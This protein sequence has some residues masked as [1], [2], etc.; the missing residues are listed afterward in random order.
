MAGGL[1]DHERWVRQQQREEERQQRA[2]A[3]A[4][5]AAERE[6]K[7]QHTAACQAQVELLKGKLD[8]RIAELESILRHGLMRSSRLDLRSLRRVDPPPSLDLGERAY[9]VPRPDWEQFRPPAPGVLGGFFGGRNRYA[10]Q[11]ADAEATFA[12]AERDRDAAEDRRQAWVREQR[13]AHGAR[14][15]S[16]QAEVDAH[17]ADIVGWHKGCAARDRESVERYLKAISERVPLPRDLPKVA[18]IAYSPRGEQVVARVELPGTD[19]VP[20]V[21]RYSYVVSK[22]EQRETARPKA[23]VAQLYRSIVSQIALLYVRDLFDA[24]PALQTVDVNGHVH[25]TNPATGHREYPCLISVT[26]ERTV[27]DSLNLREVSPQDCLRHL[28]ALVSPHPYEVEP[29]TPIREFDLT[30]FA[31]VDGLDAVSRLDSRPD[32]I[33]MTSTEFEHFVRQVFEAMGMEGWTTERTGDDGIDAVVLNRDPIIGGLTVVQAKKYSRVL[34]V[35]HIRELAG[36]M[37]EKRA[38]RGILVTTSWFTS[39]CWTKAKDNGRIELIDGARLVALTRDHL[40]KNVVIGGAPG[41]RGD[42]P[43]SST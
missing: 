42:R 7:Q 25:T 28:N 20:L 18:E 37:D 43:A 21:A 41:K 36:A 8:E 39:G 19:V 35:S 6:R 26:V 30:R 5:R 22:D 34:G 40:G 27:F 33:E 17:N 4:E 2:A 1:S 13:A 23:Q 29:V 10:R 38:G 16:H 3:A 24:D 12:Q 31:F 32:L 14:V 9:T 15:R 11:M